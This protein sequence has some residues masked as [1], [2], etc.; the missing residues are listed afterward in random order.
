MGE[1]ERKGN[2]GWKDKGR[3]GRDGKIREGEVRKG[4][5]RGKQKKTTEGEVREGKGRDRRLT[6]DR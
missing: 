5:G 1:G 4:K 6:A 2:Q 3:A